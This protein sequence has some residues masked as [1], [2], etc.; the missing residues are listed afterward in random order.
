MPYD[1][2]IEKQA[3]Y[4]LVE[5]SGNREHGREVIDSLMGWKKV[6]EMCHVKKLH[7][8]L[9]V[10]K[11]TGRLPTFS[12][13]EIGSVPDTFGWGHKF[14]GA[15]VDLNKESIEDNRFG[16]TVANNRGY[17][18]KIFDNVEDAKEWLAQ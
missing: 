7:K 5:V 2:K 9:T 12:A 1:Y 18:I 16:E 14:K 13:Y 10:L 15:I 8:V 6:A 11:L 17:R 3:D 4:L